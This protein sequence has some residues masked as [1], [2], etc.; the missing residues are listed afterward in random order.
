MYAIKSL[1][2]AIVAHPQLPKPE[3]T[4]VCLDDVQ[5]SSLVTHRGR[6]GDSGWVARD[7][8]RCQCA[9]DVGALR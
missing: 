1:S 7:D 8:M 3:G 4:Q 9:R 2:S 5:M 6:P